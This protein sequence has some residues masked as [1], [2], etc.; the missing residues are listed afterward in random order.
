[1][2][3]YLRRLGY[4]IDGKRG[5]RLMRISTM[6]ARRSSSSLGQGHEPDP[7]LLRYQLIAHVNQVW[8]TEITYVPM[9]RGFICLVAVIDWHSRY[10]L[11][12][13]FPTH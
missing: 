3:A 2:T 1:M 10:V 6:Y 5:R 13:G 9:L 12:L 11:A 7:H 4:A 8:S